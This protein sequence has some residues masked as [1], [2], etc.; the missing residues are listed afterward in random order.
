MN[1][2]EL[3]KLAGTNPPDASTVEFLCEQDDVELA[4]EQDEPETYD[5]V[6]QFLRDEGLL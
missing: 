2:K 4:T 6:E 1:V 3:R 5:A